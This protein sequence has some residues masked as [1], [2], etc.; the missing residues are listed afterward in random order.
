VLYKT[1]VDEKPIVFIVLMF[2]IR[3]KDESFATFARR[4]EGIQR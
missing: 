1:V 3:E 2:L 4:E